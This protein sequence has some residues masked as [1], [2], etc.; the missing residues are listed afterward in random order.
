[1]K[2]SGLRTHS[3]HELHAEVS[4]PGAAR[5]RSLEFK[6]T[7]DIRKI[8]GSKEL[9]LMRMSHLHG[10]AARGISAEE[11]SLIARWQKILTPDHW[12]P[13]LLSWSRAL[14]ACGTGLDILEDITYRKEEI[15]VAGVHYPLS[16]RS[17][18][19]YETRR[20]RMLED[21]PY[22]PAFR[23]DRYPFFLKPE[24]CMLCQNITRIIDH[25]NE[26]HSHENISMIDLGEYYLLPNRYPGQPGSCLLLPKD[27]DD[28]SARM[29][30]IYQGK[31]RSIPRHPGKTRGR[32]LSSSD[33]LTLF[34]LCD[35]L[36]LT[37]TRGHPLDAMSIPEH[38]HF[39]LFP[40]P[41]LDAA[42]VDPILRDQETFFSSVDGA[43]FSR[44]PRTPWDSLIIK[45]PCAERLAK[46][47]T[48]LLTV[49]E[50]ADEVVTLSYH[51]KHLVLSPRHITKDS[52]LSLGGSVGIHLFLTFN[53][54]IASQLKGGIP[55]R[56]HY[57]WPEFIQRALEHL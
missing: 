47:A 39:H 25:D 55:L 10:K 51:K 42:V 38:D 14:R 15:E 17:G 18:G 35:T 19:G 48:A 27:H 30:I 23:T 43:T 41:L 32:I 6:I 44:S 31:T 11:S 56:G 28:F 2:V 5:S 4:K 24:S 7:Q 33:L 12:A 36:E 8:L 49:L 3:E 52:P 45:A 54:E 13:F 16:I 26:Q 9:L 46:V 1:M 34:M 40:E 37:G 22:H 50:E 29:P 21:E 57:R 53:D 20:V